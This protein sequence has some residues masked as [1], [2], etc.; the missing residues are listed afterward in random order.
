MRNELL[1][2]VVEVDAAELESLG[3]FNRPL[4]DVPQVDTMAPT[5]MPS[6]FTTD[7]PAPVREPGT[8]RDAVFMIGTAV[9]LIVVA[10]VFGIKSFRELSAEEERSALAA[11]P[12]V[13]PRLVR[14]AKSPPPPVSEPDPEPVAPIANAAAVLESS[15]PVAVAPT[16]TVVTSVPAAPATPALATS[17]TDSAPAPAPK[18]EVTPRPNLPQ[19]SPSQWVA[20]TRVQPTES[21]PA[22][23]PAASSNPAS[24]APT[25]I[26]SPA[27]TTD[28]A[29]LLDE[30]KTLERRGDEIMAERRTE[31]ALDLYRTALTSAVEYANRKGANP[32]AKDQVVMLLRKLGLLQ[33]QNASTAEARSTFQ[34]ARKTLLQIKAKGVWSRERDKILDELE[35]RLL[36]LPRD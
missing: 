22:P 33:L 6:S 13:M 26:T 14:L 5:P 29:V 18:T 31:D 25:A 19:V 12:T 35:S 20:M 36:S 30:V 24:P 32:V 11:T 21:V 23:A 9:V 10:V 8:Q 17:E 1:T 28:D 15:T 7:F 2:A 4:P 16:P 34:Q 27:S 3:A